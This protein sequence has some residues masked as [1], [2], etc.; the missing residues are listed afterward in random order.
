MTAV[1][2]QG[3]TLEGFYDTDAVFTWN[4][5]GTI[6]N[7]A[8][9]GK[10]MSQDTSA[11]NT[12]HLAGDGEPL[13]GRLMSYESRTV[14]G[15]TVGSIAEEG[16]FRFAYTGTLAIGNSVVGAG[17]GT[18]KQGANTGA[19]D[20]HTRVVDIDTVGHTCVVEIL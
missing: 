16:N 15:I 6:S 19:F 3:V 17:S 2:G 12:A 8:D 5:S 14:E 13:I 18:V 11:A 1:I 4:I 7:P 20:G 9:I 10:A